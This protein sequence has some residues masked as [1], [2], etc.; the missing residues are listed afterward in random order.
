MTK[1]IEI[2]DEVLAKVESQCPKYLSPTGFI[3]L[4]IDQAL[5]TPVTL[6]VQSAAGTPSTSSSISKKKESIT[7]LSICAELQK[8]EELI[9]EFWRLK[10]GSKGSTAWK[11]LNTELKNLQA[12]YGDAV[13]EEQI[14]LAINGKWAGIR[15][16]NYEA[17]KA[18]KGN[19]PAQPEYKH[20]AYRSAAEVLE[21]QE[22]IAQQNIEH[23]R[24][25]NAERE[26]A[27]GVLDGLF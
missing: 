6:G 24:M 3:N 8:H 10:K 16:S 17:F 22:R 18:P 5:D 23:L 20:P 25:K 21:E 9:R 12:K 27:G 19:A 1:R 13:V 11:L 15:L 14:Q 7:T 2:D 26:A 4:L